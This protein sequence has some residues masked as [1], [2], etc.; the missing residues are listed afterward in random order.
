MV[1]T[2]SRLARAHGDY[3]LEGGLWP[4]LH[5]SSFERLL[6]PKTDRWLVRTVAGL[7]LANGLVQL[8]SEDD[9]Q[10]ARQA[11]RIGVGT[12]A[13]LGAID[14]IYAPS[15]RISKVY[16]LDAVLE[17]GWIGAWLMPRRR[18]SRHLSV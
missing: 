4:L 12:A 14:L 2:H 18:A 13:T 5:M 15:G 8:R 1:L 17:L 3:N 6:G 9:P 10:G 16:L 7:M 11:R